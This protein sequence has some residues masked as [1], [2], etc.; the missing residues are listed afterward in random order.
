M[1]I[2]REISTG[3]TWKVG[4]RYGRCRLAFACY[5]KGEMGW[6]NP[7]TIMLVWRTP[8]GQ[9]QESI[10]AKSLFEIIDE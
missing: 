6:P 7:E 2:V 3:A 9:K 10:Y 8:S 4:E 1:A 5:P